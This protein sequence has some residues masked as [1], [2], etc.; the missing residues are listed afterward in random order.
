MDLLSAFLCLTVPVFYS[1]F[2]LT[3][4][5]T[6]LLP[7]GSGVFLL[8]LAD[9][10]SGYL[11]LAAGLILTIPLLFCRPAVWPRGLAAW[12]VILA[13]VGAPLC[14]VRGIPFAL[15][16]SPAGLG[17]LCFA[18]ALLLAG[19]LLERRNLN[20]AVIPRLAGKLALFIL[21]LLC[22]ALL[23]AYAIPFSSGPAYELHQILHG[24]PAPGFGSG[25]IRIWQETL[26]L[27]GEAPL[28]GGG[29]DTLVARIPFTFTRD[30]AEL[31]ITIE[32]TIDTA[33]NEFLNIAVNQGLPA[34]GFYLAM[35]A[36]LLW[37]CL[38]Y[39]EQSPIL[40]LLPGILAYLAQ[41][42]FTYSYC[43]V[44]A[45]FW[46]FLALCEQTTNFQK[47]ELEK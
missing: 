38:K 40:F 31:G 4:R 26:H 16:L 33:H 20:D 35:L 14:T 7:M 13:A 27:I 22:I 44:A 12:G 36:S 9:V 30:S 24:N 5:K 45:L 10:D 17:L 37:R 34:L 6:A 23:A 41:S 8:M 32:T 19:V 28:F 3:G 21:S 1:A 15:R 29:P 11:G 39:R 43:A 18:L 2:L 25:R 47:E 46:V 42:C